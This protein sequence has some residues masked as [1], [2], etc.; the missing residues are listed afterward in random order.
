MTTLEFWLDVSRV[1]TVVGAVWVLALMARGHWRAG[2][3][4]R[5]S[6]WAGLLIDLS[7][8]TFLI[9]ILIRRLQ[10]DQGLPP[11]VAWVTTAAVIAAAVAGWFRSHPVS[12]REYR[13]LRAAR[14]ARARE[15]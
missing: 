15:P 9:V 6:H 10:H 1:V 2:W 11:W 3:P 13:R 12:R 4:R 8:A 14:Q 5:R 7:F